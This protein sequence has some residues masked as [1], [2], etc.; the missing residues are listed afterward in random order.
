MS[1][2]PKSVSEVPAETARVARAAFRKGNP[3]LRFRDEFGS[4]FTDH[5]FVQLYPRR[6]QP[7]SSPSQL[8]L[9][10]LVQFAENLTDR[11]MADQ[12]RARIDLKYLLNLELTDTGFDFSVLSEFRRRLVN[13]NAEALLLNTMLER[14]REQGL[15]KAHGQQRSDSTHVLAAIRLL[16]R[17]ELVGETMRAALNQLAAQFPEWI[18]QVAAPEWF[19]RYGHRIEDTRLPKGQAARQA[20]AEQVGTDGFKLLA[21]LDSDEQCLTM[22]ALSSVHT[23]RL[24]WAHHFKEVDGKASWLPGAELLP[25]AERFESPYDTDTRCGNKAGSNW[26]G[27]R[28]HLSETCDNERPHLITHVDTTL[29]TVPDVSMTAVLHQAL[30]DKN[31]LPD[32]HLVDSGYVDAELLAT[33]HATFGIDLIGPARRDKSW[34]AKTEGAFDF[35]AFRV[36][37]DGQVVTCP[38]GAQT[39]SWVER[40]G[41]YGTPTIYAK[42]AKKSCKTCELK[43]KCTRGALRTLT[44]QPQAVQEALNLAR[45][46]ESNG[47]WQGLYQRRAGIEATMSQGV[48]AFGLRRARYR[49]LKKTSLQHACTGAAINLVRVVDWISEKPRWKDRLSQ[50]AALRPVA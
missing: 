48:R 14:F 18:Q 49:G 42:F 19:T 16:N 22:C 32:E 28:V 17:T 31:L 13:G 40:P 5:D 35:T 24:A 9:V 20:Y 7:A 11:Q 23:L 21:A 6:G 10:T 50:F 12:V 1:L 3:Y 41:P 36:D 29:A 4:L 27:Y 2:Q 45:T 46:R 15:V 47:T 44:F 38:N 33:S 8:A 30:S 25:A 39:S 26:I 37:W 34:Q 43:E